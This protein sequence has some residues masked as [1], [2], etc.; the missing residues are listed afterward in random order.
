MPKVC[1]E[2]KYEECLNF[3]F[4]LWMSYCPFCDYTLLDLACLS[5]PSDGRMFD[6]VEEMMKWLEEDTPEEIEH[7]KEL[8][9]I[10]IGNEKLAEVI[11]RE[12]R[13]VK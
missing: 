7:R 11:N 1:L 13:N 4:P 5:A 6:S 8:E 3:K 10:K 2:Q 9:Q 12:K